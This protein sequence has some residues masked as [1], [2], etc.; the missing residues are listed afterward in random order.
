M[1]KDDHRVVLV[2]HTHDRNTG[3]VLECLRQ[4]QKISSLDSQRFNGH[5]MD[6]ISNGKAAAVHTHLT[7]T[8]LI[9]VLQGTETLITQSLNSPG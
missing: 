6:L 9:T 5:L 2:L 7:R 8:I 4:S 3:T 1:I